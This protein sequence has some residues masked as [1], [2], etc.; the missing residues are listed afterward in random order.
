MNKFTRRRANQ[1]GFVAIAYAAMIVAILGF[2]GLAVDVGYMQYQKRRIQAAA[3]AAAMGALREM[4][5]SQTDLTAA[6]Q[7]DAS[8]NG[9]TDGQ[10]NT[11]VTINNPPTLGSYANNSSAVEAIVQR[12][13]PTFFMMI[14]GQ[15]GVTL[16]A[17]AVARTASDAG[18]IGACIYA[19]NPTASAALEI[20]GTNM[21]LSTACSAVVESND[22]SAF[23]MNS[24]VQVQMTN[25][26]QVGV[27]G[28]WFISGGAALINSTTG[29]PES[30]VNIK[31][32]TDPLASVTAPTPQTVTGGVQGTN[33]SIKSNNTAL[34]TSLNPGVYCGGLTVNSTNGTLT[35][36]AGTYVLA[37]GGLSITGGTVVGSGVTFYNTT[38][39]STW[40]CSGNG[41]AQP[42]TINGGANVT[43][44]ATTQANSSSGILFFEDR[45]IHTNGDT[46][47]GNATSSFDGALYF[48]ND[49]LTFAGTNATNG[50]LVI[51]ADT[52]K[53]NGN[54]NLGNDYKTLTNIYTIAPAAT[55]GGLVE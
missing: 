4:E 52:I 9:F 27:V 1:R 35:L 23:K 47:N 12:K 39:G 37:G 2:T 31:S 33:M 8:L 21:N 42:V 38:G 44:S 26:A 40:G 46:I 51:V 25:G 55:G 49:Q 20:N 29:K 28:N 16:S 45:G 17:R 30:P 36:N 43:L 6:G 11:T 15:N 48:V 13:V 41:N 34:N 18:S 14:F 19:L 24:S 32:F 3:D 10:G 5:R 50:Y 7:Y 54:S 22:P 53:I